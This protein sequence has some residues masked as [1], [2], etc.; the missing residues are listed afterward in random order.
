MAK[1]SPLDL[2]IL[3]FLKYIPQPKRDDYELI[4]RRCNFSDVGD[5]LFPVMLFLLFLQDN[6]ADGTE[7]L[8]VEIKSLK[9]RLEST[10]IQENPVK[11]S[12]WKII[13]IVLAA[14]QIF[15][16]IF[17]IYK[18]AE[19]PRPVRTYEPTSN[20][21]EIQKLN[22]YWDMKLEHAKN[23][24]Q[25]TMNET[26]AKIMFPALLILMIII[27][28][29]DIFMIRRIARMIR[30]STSQNEESPRHNIKE[31]CEITEGEDILGTLSEDEGRPE[32]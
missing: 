5:P 3:D 10:G 16:S 30:E 22:F 17:C 19:N 18:I 8:A 25:N 14:I 26:L 27:M 2:V 32:S 20:P 11:T 9:S 4:L 24:R 21:T 6:L 7:N 15:L 28:I 13:I 1:K 29:A 31:L 12:R 23:E